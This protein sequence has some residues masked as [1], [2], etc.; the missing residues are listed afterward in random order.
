MSPAFGSR[1]RAEEFDALL[2]GT[3]TQPSSAEL[4]DLVAFAERVWALPEIEPRRDFADDLRARLMAEAPAALAFARP[5]GAD[6]E[7]IERI[8]RIER[9][10]VRRSPSAP[11]RERRLA[12]AIA[13]FSVVGA[14][15]ASAMASQGALP[16]DTLYPVKRLVENAQTS[17]SMGE[18]AK[19]DTL[20]AQARTRLAEARTLA[21]RGDEADAGAISDTLDDF[22]SKAAHASD[23]VLDEYADR[24]DDA[25]VEGL[26]SFAAD[27]VAT[28]DELSGLVPADAEGALA[29]ATRTLLGID[30]AAAQTCPSCTAQGVTDIPAT[31]AQL[32][33]SATDGVRES[34]A[35]SRH[36]RAN[37]PSEA[38]S[39]SPG[40]ASQAP[41][42]DQQA[43]GPGPGSGGST[44]G[45]TAPT[46]QPSTIGGVVGGVGGAVGDTVS[47][48][49]DAV[50]GVGGAI[51]GPVGG[52][53]SGVGGVVSG[54]GGAVGGTVGSVGGLV[55]GVVGGLLGGLTSTTSPK[56]SPT[57]KP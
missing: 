20:L 9:L 30:A 54:V 36:P 3:L 37:R 47:G 13:A 5:A 22:S 34:L 53:V 52:V 18:E 27:G 26:R 35:P 40:A 25:R 16:G 2:E 10:T 31:L 8:E 41:A 43:G 23:L 14:T 21:R 17:L 28:L 32:L 42:P 7:R 48:V 38:T 15:A 57:P 6:T 51:G 50:T 39:P 33:S 44:S 19:A 29:K 46:S 12:V 4:R 11:R 1:R 55:D 56:P 45:P 49:G 24:R